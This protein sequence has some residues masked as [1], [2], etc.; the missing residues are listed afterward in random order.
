MNSPVPCSTAESGAKRKAYVL[1]GA[2]LAL[3]FG[4]TPIFFNLDAYLAAFIWLIALWTVTLVCTIWFFRIRRRA[5]W[6]MVPYLLWLTFAG[7][8]NYSIY[9]LSITPMPLPR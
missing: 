4:W 6:L 7:Y 5:G 1:Y 9:I 8:L 3:N 2:Q